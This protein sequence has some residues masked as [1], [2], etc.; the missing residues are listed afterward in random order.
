MGE[1]APLFYSI[2]GSTLLTAIGC[3][4]L[5]FRKHKTAAISYWLLTIK[6]GLTALFLLAYEKSN[7]LYYAVLFLCVIYL[8]SL[9]IV[10]ACMYREHSTAPKARSVEVEQEE[11]PS[12]ILLPGE[13][14]SLRKNSRCN[15]EDRRIFHEE[16]TDI[17]EDSIDGDW[18]IE[19][20]ANNVEPFEQ[21][22]PDTF[23]SKSRLKE[24]LSHLEDE[25]LKELVKD[26]LS[27]METEESKVQSWAILGVDF[28][29]ELKL[30][31]KSYSKAD[32]EIIWLLMQELLTSLARKDCELIDED[33]WTPK[34]QRAVRVERTLPEG[35]APV[36][37]SKGRSGLIVR[38]ELIRKQEVSVNLS[39]NN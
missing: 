15:S 33:V 6:G 3:L 5:L 34:R 4:I 30:M 37:L 9:I 19:T 28:L 1:F 18:P 25:N 38:G 23:I 20:Y 16:N 22:P 10:L 36:I 32:E 13:Y 31:Q 26:R 14:D 35:A 8:L 7:I 39:P 21:S 29:D 12:P 27:E 2:C 17:S 24:L 11:A